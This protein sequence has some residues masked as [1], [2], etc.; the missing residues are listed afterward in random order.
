MTEYALVAVGRPVRGEFT[1]AV[2]ESLEGQ[3]QPGQRIRVPFG[4]GITLGFYLGPAEQP[5]EELRQKLKPIA[6]VLDA[7]PAF[8]PEVVALVRFAAQHYRY[9][10]GEALRMA[11]PPGLTD[12]VEEKEAKADTVAWAEVVSGAS[13]EGLKRAPA[14]QAALSYLLAVGGRALVDEVAHAIPGAKDS[15]KKLQARG[16]IN[17]SSEIIVKG[18]REGLQAERHQSLTDEQTSALTELSASFDAQTFAPYLL[19]GVTGSGKTEVYLQ[20]VERALAQNRGALILVPEIALTPQLVGRFKSRFGNRVALL[21]SAL[22]D[23]ERL[24]HWQQLRKGEVT[25]AVGVRS[26]IFAPVKNLGVLVVD[27]EHDPSFKQDEKLRYNARDLAVVRGQHAGA[28]VVLGSATPSLETLENVRRGRYRLVQMKKRVDDRPMPTISLVDLRTERPKDHATPDNAVPMLSAPLRQAIGETLSKG[29]QT[30]LFLN[31]RGHS[32][33]LVCV[34]CGQSLRCPNCDVALTQHLSTRTLQCH[35][36]GLSEPVPHECPQC[37]GEILKLGFGTERIEAE[38]A[39]AYPHARVARLDRDAVTSAERL[40]EMLAGFARRE[41][42]ILV[43]TQMVAKGHDFPGVTLVAIIMADAALAL[44]DFRASER[45]F[46]LLT[47]VAGRAG[48]GVD[49][50]RVLV[51]SYNPEA[52]AVA[53]MLRH[54]FEGFSSDE[55]RRRQVLSWPPASRLVAL[56]IEGSS[57]DQ[58]ARAARQLVDVGARHLPPASHGVRLLGPAPAPIARIKGQSRWQVMLLGPSHAAL[59]KTLRAMERVID[60]LPRGVKVVVDVDPGAML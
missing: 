19:H 37:R 55:L 29:Q 57:A 39:D 5:P 15:L 4:R 21:H 24:R 14:Q 6:A 16:L 41:I 35:Y 18:V 11:L 28:L 60:E 53:H 40:T 38:V 25:I 33:F 36:C 13:V 59:E 52:S 27:E 1:Y 46:H 10:L 49:P 9:P 8:S 54:D 23:R 22:K 51:Q 32:T 50:G 44:P 7:T 30:I 3:L 17:F 12:A 48:R 58:T 34:V 42:D 56:R 45:T 31:R 20:L 43:G 2:P 26:A 47:Q